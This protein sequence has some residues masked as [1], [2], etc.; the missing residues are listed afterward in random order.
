MTPT[1]GHTGLGRVALVTKSGGGEGARIAR[2]VGA[3]LAGRG[4]A[5]VY[6]ADTAAA[7]A[8]D[9]GFPRAAVPPDVDLVIAIGG[10]GTLLGAAR[11]AVPLGLPVLG[12]NFGSLG[13]LTELQPDE[14][15]DGL[16]AVIAGRYSIE[17]RQTLRVRYSREGELQ[18][19]YAVLN[20]A[21]L[22][23]SA[24]ARMVGIRL[25]VDDEHVATYTSD[26]LIVATPTGSTAYSLSAGG[27]ILDPRMS[28]FVIAPIC[29]H[30]MT[31]RPLVVPGSVRL[32]IALDEPG[33]VVFLTLDGQIGFP[34]DARD[35]LTVDRHPNP[36]RLVRVTRRPF[37]EVLRRKLRWGER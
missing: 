7:L 6:D 11:S 34:F 32:E 19:E 9:P 13:F 16:A 17:E 26:G 25:Q 14:V 27:P 5:V 21:V 8:A 37:F 33:E 31:Y 15:Y 2:D 20:D 28:A 1:T 18:Q 23:K 35:A 36:A 22:T 3:W 24:L 10:D 29:P 4:V 30:T 12:V